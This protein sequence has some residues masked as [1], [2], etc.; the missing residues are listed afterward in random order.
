MFS[1]LSGGTKRTTFFDQAARNVACMAEILHR[2]EEAPISMNRLAFVVLA[3]VQQI[4]A[5]VFGRLCEKDSIATKVQERMRAYEGEKTK[6]HANASV[7]LLERI[8]ILLLS[9]EQVINEIDRRDP[10]AASAFREFYNRCLTFNSRA[11]ADRIAQ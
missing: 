5:G 1:P 7:P 3:P 4:E 9:W 8:Q 6:W 11:G 2:A 10:D